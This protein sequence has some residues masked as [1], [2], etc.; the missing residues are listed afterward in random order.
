MLTEPSTL[1][2]IQITSDQLLYHSFT[3]DGSIY[4]SIKGGN[5]AMTKDEKIQYLINLWVELGLVSLKEEIPHNQ[6][7]CLSL[8][9]LTD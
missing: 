3:T 8:V 1:T 9:Q 2:T 7:C 4:Y 6:S 5:M